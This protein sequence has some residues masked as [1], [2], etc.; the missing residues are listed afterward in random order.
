MGVV[1][2]VLGDGKAIGK[3]KEV[4]RRAI[5]CAKAAEQGAKAA[6]HLQKR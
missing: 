2:E 6:G 5:E 3:S 1:G 4:V